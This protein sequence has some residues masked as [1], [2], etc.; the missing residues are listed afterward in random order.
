[1]NQ[2]TSPPD[3]AQ[4]AKPRFGVRRHTA[5]LKTPP[6][7][8]FARPANSPTIAEIRLL[9]LYTITIF[10]SATLL[11]LVQP[12]FARMVLPLLGGS[13]AVWNTAMVFFQAALLAGY[14]YSH[15]ATARFGAR[16][17]SLW[18]LA[19]L[20][21]PLAVL[22][23]K[24]PP[25]WTPPANANPLPWLLGLLTVAVGLPFF[26][27][28]TMSP[29]L[30][31]W[32]AA[33]GHRHARDPYFL[34]AASNLGSL[35]ALVSYPLVVEPVW[36]LQEQS[37]LWTMGYILLVALALGCA[38][39]LR[40]VPATVAVGSEAAV[41][42]ARAL[43]GESGK[44]T[45]RRRARWV[46]LAFVPSSL[47]LGVTTYLT[48][49][50]AAVPLFWIVP[51]ALYLVT[52]I[53]AFSGRARARRLLTRA[54]PMLMVGL[55]M[56]FALRATQPAALLMLLH[57]AVFFVAALLCHGA[58]GD[59]RP[60][61]EH[62]TEFYLWLSV[63]GVLGGVFNA[64][65][66]P[67]LFR[68]VV[69]Y[70]LVLVLA[71]L[72]AM[73]GADT[74]PGR[75]ARALDFAA[76]FVLGL[77]GTGLILVKA[78][79]P[80]A[81]FG[82]ATLVCFFFSERPVRFALGLAAV[83]LIA[84]LH[85]GA[86]GRVLHLERS[87]FGIHRV[88]LAPGG[89]QHLLVHGKI[90]HG[91]QSLDPAKRKM[92]LTYYHPTGPIGQV[93][94]VANIDPR[95][96]VAVVG[97][98]AGSLAGYGLPR[99]PWTFYEIDPVVERL[100]RNTNYFTFLGDSAA[101][102]RVV[103]GDAR[104]SLA[105]APDGAYR[106]L[107]LDAYSADAIPVHLLTREA[108]ALYT[109]KLAPGGLLAFHISNQHF[110]LEPVLAA[111][112]RDAGLVCKVQDNDTISAAEHDEGKRESVWAVMAGQPD[113]LGVLGAGP[114]WRPAETRPG[115]DVWTDGRASALKVFRWR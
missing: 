55:A 14:G 28:A 30:Q 26:A 78:L 56:V 65:L 4:N 51:L 66:A 11:F 50:I 17:Q 89:G 87:F 22:P 19:V 36:S 61:P 106:L 59:D 114:R 81:V 46:F 24:I 86:H 74:K 91:M 43:A 48:S 82:A 115:V 37:R 97:L 107:V 99:Q 60:A 52:F 110:S 88:T 34:Y 21:L 98:G 85:E 96:A 108:L 111:L 100:A 80:Q 92:P 70:P 33:T 113:A 112:A 76:P 77:A 6:I 31:K 104:L 40:R 53:L 62:L 95:A 8:S 102:V 93:F 15:A 16:R 67:L 83:F 1:M 5:V 9:P 109:R 103:L 94:A 39:A 101:N 38:L 47:M 105:S 69:E 29:L 58:L 72:A 68:S 27:V 42:N 32:F 90:I 25:G 75:R 73:P 10:V 49:D 18:H 64:L 57:L 13:P 20:L 41:R 2:S 3:V 45:S 23:L 35:L 84:P 7:F 44:L 63:G 54:L 79:P 12:M 71:C